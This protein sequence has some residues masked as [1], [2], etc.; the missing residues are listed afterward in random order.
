MPSLSSTPDRTTPQQ[1][2][3][4]CRVQS[5]LD[6]AAEIF[7]EAGYEATT[8]TAIAER[9]ETSIGGLYRYFP[10]KPAVAQ[11]LLRRYSLRAESYWTS[12]IQEAKELSVGR[13]AE[14][15]LDRME[16]FV[17]ENPAYLVLNAA[18]VKFTRDATTR[19]NVRIRFSEAFQA[20]NPSLTSERAQLIANVALQL[21]RGMLTLYAE[22]APK[23]R[24][25]INAEFKRVLAN[26]LGEVLDAR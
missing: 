16:E 24:P 11:A 8:M 13:F 26:Y 18:P 3:A 4:C 9:S 20:K 19:R 15:L 1:D 2:R 25:R 7:G 17:A 10:D 6:A 12:L 5:L 14:L 22:G 21:I 23:E